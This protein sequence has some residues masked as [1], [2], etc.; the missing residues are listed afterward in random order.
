MELSLQVLNSK[1]HEQVARDRKVCYMNSLVP[2]LTVSSLQSYDCTESSGGLLWIISQFGD[3]SET[4][5][6]H[7][8]ILSLSGRYVVVDGSGAVSRHLQL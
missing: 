1:D 2:Q 5:Y 7:D 6:V 8:G 4:P 3:V